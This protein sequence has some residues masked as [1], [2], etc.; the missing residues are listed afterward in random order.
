MTAHDHAPDPTLISFGCI[1]DA[2]SLAFD[3][4]ARVDR[5]QLAAL[6]D[7]D[8]LLEATAFTHPDHTLD[9]A[10]GWSLSFAHLL[11]VDRPVMTL[12]SVVDY[13][14][15]ELREGDLATF[16]R[17]RRMVQ[18]WLEVRDW[19]VTNG[20]EVRSIGIVALGPSAW[21]NCTDGQCATWDGDPDIGLW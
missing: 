10:F 19:L 6:S 20:Q 18:P 2:V 3:L 11:G 17:Y 15:A 5:A 7:G 9:H 14:V 8:N 4:A 1:D 13:D 21:P 12:F 16:R